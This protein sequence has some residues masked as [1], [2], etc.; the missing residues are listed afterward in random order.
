MFGP[1]LPKRRLEPEHRGDGRQ[2][3]AARAKKSAETE[4]S[5]LFSRVTCQSVLRI[6]FGVEGS[7]N[8]GVDI[9]GVLADIGADQEIIDNDL[10]GGLQLRNIGWQV[11]AQNFA[12]QGDGSIGDFGAWRARCIGTSGTSRA[13]GAIGTSGTYLT[14]RA[15]VASRTIRTG[16]TLVTLG[17]VGSS[18]SL[19]RHPEPGF[20]TTLSGVSFAKGAD[21]Y[22]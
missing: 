20:Y 18:R 1:A 22:I 16:Y 17:T 21:S 7:L 11:L 4:I 6:E 8:P 13:S 14:L 9:A 12:S 3:Y 10:G 5:A 15:L 2:R 19:R